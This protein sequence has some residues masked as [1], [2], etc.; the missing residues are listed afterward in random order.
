MSQSAWAVLTTC[1]RRGGSSNRK[2]FLLVLEPSVVRTP[3]LACPSL[4]SRCV[5]AR[6]RGSEGREREGE[7][8][9]TYKYTHTQKERERRGVRER[10]IIYTQ[11]ETEKGRKEREK[12]GET[13][14]Q[15]ER[16]REGEGEGKRRIC[17]HTKWGEGRRERGER[18]PS[19]STGLSSSSHKDL[20][21]HHG[22]FTL[23]S[24]RSR[25]PTSKYQHCRSWAL[26]HECGGGFAN[27]QDTL[28]TITE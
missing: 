20:S 9:N 12:E 1:H 4:P 24:S 23:M 18:E 13:G 26:L 7:R 2:G 27:S 11:R 17:T 28:L 3:S 8:R 19:T 14:R 25:G 10:N 22:S 16:E 21:P 15:E 5:L 6:H